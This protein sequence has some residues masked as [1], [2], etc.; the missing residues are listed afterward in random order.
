MGNNAADAI[1]AG[2]ICLDI[3]PNL[4]KQTKSFGELITPGNLVVT[5]PAMISTGGAVSNTGLALHRLGIPVELMGK[6]GRDL[7]GEGIRGVLQSYG[8]RLAD[9]MIVSDDPSSHSITINFPGVDRIFLH[10]PGANDTFGAGDID[11]DALRGARLFHFGYPTLMR[12]MYTNEGAE[13]EELF[14]R[15]R[16]AG[17]TTSLDM[18]WVDP[19]SEAGRV[20]WSAM[21]QRLLPHVDVFL[22]S[23]DEILYMVDREKFLAFQKAGGGDVL[24]QADGDL[25]GRVAQTLLDLGAAIVVLKLGHQGLYVRV[26]ENAERLQAIGP[27]APKD[28]DA[29]LG[30]ELLAPCFRVDVAGATGSGDCTI[31]GFLAGLLHGLHP[32]ET[33]TAGVATGACNVEAPDATSGL[34]SWDDMQ[35]RIQA[36]WARREM[37][38]PFAGW[39]FDKTA[40]VYRKG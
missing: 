16:Q 37:T 24:S 21:L 26:T 23:F 15:A 39:S 28:L 34:Y 38:L 20:N 7:F 36:G 2:H 17:P 14:R 8:E 25:I 32:V 27:C 3:I 10:C 33:I 29:W 31:A 1:V 22:P 35:A 6:I 9:G 4:D 18:A 40:G 19:D 5:E 11:Y 12:R 30:C 13:L